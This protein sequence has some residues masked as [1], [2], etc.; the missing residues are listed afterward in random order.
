D[1]YDIDGDG[2]TNEPDGLVDHLMV[3]HAGVGQEAG[4]GALGDNAIWSH[5]WVLNGV[6]PFA[7]TQASVPY[8]GGYMA[9]YD[10]TV[11]PEDGAV[12]VF[13]HEYGHDLGLPD[14][15]DTQYTGDGEPIASW[16]IMSGGSWNGA[17]AG[18][19]PTSFSPQNKEFFQKTIGGN[20]A[21]MT[22]VD[23]K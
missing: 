10:Y 14:E 8:W 19:T 9:A 20:W 7:G 21:N 4:G 22:E 11:E 13:A 12:G 5:R 2:N 17:I 3:I 23:Y 18:T 1:I 15:Y 16:S 6:T